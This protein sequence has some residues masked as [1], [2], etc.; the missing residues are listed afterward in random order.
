MPSDSSLLLLKL[1]LV[2]I[3]LTNGADLNILGPGRLLPKDIEGC[4][5]SSTLNCVRIY[6][7]KP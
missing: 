2:V 5:D 4:T 3:T 7:P 1:F 6:H